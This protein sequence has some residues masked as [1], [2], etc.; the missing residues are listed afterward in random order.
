M[1]IVQVEWRKKL[2]RQRLAQSLHFG[3]RAHLTQ[4]NGKLIAAETPCQMAFS[5]EGHQ[6]AGD[7][8]QHFIACRV[9]P[10][11]IDQ[12]EVIAVKKQ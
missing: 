3:F 10:V 11:V 12:L 9:P 4:Q 7:L 5:G 1:A 2:F 8:R 6:A